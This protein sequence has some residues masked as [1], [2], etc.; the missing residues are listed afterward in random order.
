MTGRPVV[1]VSRL[2]DPRHT[3]LEGPIRSASCSL[4]GI[5]HDGG[6]ALPGIDFQLDEG[7]RLPLA[8]PGR[9]ETGL[10]LLVLE[11]PLPNAPAHDT[12]HGLSDLV[13]GER[14]WT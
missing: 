12:R 1:R 9:Q 5:G 4:D 10:E 13:E 6:V 11:I 8:L 3:L 2:G 14:R 7:R